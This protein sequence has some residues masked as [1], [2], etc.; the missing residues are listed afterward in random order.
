MERIVVTNRILLAI[1]VALF[2]PYFVVGINK[3]INENAVQGS[4]STE[5]TE[6]KKKERK[7]LCLIASACEKYKK[8]SQECALAPNI[9]RCI[10]IKMGDAA[11]YTSYCSP[12]AY[13]MYPELSLNTPNKLKCAFLGMFE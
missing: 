5:Q 8:V 7:E 4:D 6:I 10:L 3:S 2:T 13:G 12:D 11:A 1:I 9:N